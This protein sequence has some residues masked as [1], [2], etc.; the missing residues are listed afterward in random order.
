MTYDDLDLKWIVREILANA[1]AADTTD[2]SAGPCQDYAYAERNATLHAAMVIRDRLFDKASG[3]AWRREHW[4][5]LH[6]QAQA[7]RDLYVWHGYDLDSR[8]AVNALLRWLAGTDPTAAGL[9][10][11][12]VVP[13]YR[14][15]GGDSSAPGG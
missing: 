11:A 7:A 8:D 13:D 9:W 4:A 15:E 6:R 5:A 12:C 10:T 3:N 14:A 2:V 1:T